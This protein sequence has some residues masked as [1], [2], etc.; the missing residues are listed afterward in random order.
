MNICDV[1]LHIIKQNI[2]YIKH[3]L[4]VH[5]DNI[6][7]EYMKSRNI[8]VMNMEII[9]DII[10]E[11]IS[12]VSEIMKDGVNVI[13]SETSSFTFKHAQIPCTPSLTTLTYC[14]EN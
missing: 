12:I 10:N 13:K 8:L 7:N 1:F 6:I 2:N 9:N 5:N 11:N 4:D 3:L 14:K